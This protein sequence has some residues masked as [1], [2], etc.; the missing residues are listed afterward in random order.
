MSAE[1]PE[2]GSGSEERLGK[3]SPGPIDPPRSPHFPLPDPAWEPTRGFFAA[4]ARGELAIPRCTGCGRRIWY[5]RPACP[6]CG[7][8]D[9]PWETV[10]GRGTLFS[11]A[12][13][14]RPLWRPFAERVPYATGLVALAEDPAVR[15]VTLLV[16]CAPEEL[17][18]EMAVHA[19]FRSLRFAGA[20]TEVVV[21]LFTP[22]AAAR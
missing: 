8:T 21:P 13:V 17:R 16:D 5:P 20:E 14:R 19:V 10:S 4:A 7:G 15:L 6:A 22:D 11:F 9:L 2:K 1:T 3:G 12:V 18:V